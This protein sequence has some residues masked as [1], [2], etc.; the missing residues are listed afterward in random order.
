MHKSNI[1]LKRFP[2]YDVVNPVKLFFMQE[3]PS[4]IIFSENVKISTLATSIVKK[5]SLLDQI[6]PWKGQILLLFKVKVKEMNVIF[7]DTLTFGTE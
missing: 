5:V 3:K 7:R 1:N 6:G 2:R 4:C